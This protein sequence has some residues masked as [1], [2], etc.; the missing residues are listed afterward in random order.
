MKRFL[1]AGLGGVLAAT[2]AISTFAEDFVL[3]GGSVEKKDIPSGSAKRIELTIE[4]GRFDEHSSGELTLLLENID[5]KA[6]KAANLTADV[7]DGH[8]DAVLLDELHFE[9]GAFAFDSLELMNSRRFVMKQPVN[10]KLYLEISE[11]NM[12]AF[13]SNPKTIGKLEKAI[14]KNTGG[15]RLIRFTNPVLNFEGRERFKLTLNVLLG[16]AALAPIDMFGKM[17]VDNGRVVFKELAVGEKANQLPVD[18]AR[19]FENQLNKMFDL[20]DKGGSQFQITAD[21]FDITN[22]RLK[23]DG[24]VRIEALELGN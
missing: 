23:V 9:T 8:F 18:I 19:V 21:D 13:L 2:L 3:Q 4:D 1:A 22:S 20:R 16:G 15:L 12:Q 5:F 10:A 6:G 17:A 24:H 7:R 11:D 14:A